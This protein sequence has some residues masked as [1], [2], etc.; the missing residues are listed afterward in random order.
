L[1]V[2]VGSRHQ[3]RHRNRPGIHHRV[4]PPVSAPLDRLRRVERQARRI[5]ADQLPDLLAAELLADERVD[6][7]F[8]D[9]HDRQLRPG[10][11]GGEEIARDPRDTDAEEVGAHVLECGVHPRDRPLVI[12]PVALVGFRHQLSQERG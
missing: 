10:V 5:H 2:R 12:R 9:A 1:V 3:A 8:R 7:W 11:A 6:E 4:R